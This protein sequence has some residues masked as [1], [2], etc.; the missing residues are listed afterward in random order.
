MEIIIALINNQIPVLKKMFVE[1]KRV[2]KIDI[3][4]PS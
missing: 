3:F 1:N 4:Q 2:V